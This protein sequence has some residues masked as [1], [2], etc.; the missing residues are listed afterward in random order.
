[1]TRHLRLSLQSGQM[2]ETDQRH[3]LGAHFQ[4]VG[5][6]DQSDWEQEETQL[7]IIQALQKDQGAM[8]GIFDEQKAMGLR[9]AGQSGGEDDY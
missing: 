1:M 6:V 9:K 8:G 5:G 4:A 7:G 3:V 2:V